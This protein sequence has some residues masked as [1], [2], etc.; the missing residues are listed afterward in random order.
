MVPFNRPHLTG[1]E[2]EFFAQAL[3]TGLMTGDRPFTSR[4]GALLSGMLGGGQTLLT[5]SCTHALELSAM[6]LDLGP[7]DEVI[8]PSFTFSSVA[9]AIV[10]RG[11]VP[12]F[13]DI[14]PDTFNL[15]ERLVESAITDRTR[16]V[17]TVHYGGVACAIEELVALCE[18]NDLALVEDNAHG[19]G[20]TYKD[21]PL[22]SFGRLATQSF[23][24]TKNVQCGDGGALVINDPDLVE[25]AEILRDKGTD[26]NR[27]DRGQ[28][29]KYVWRDIG[30]SYLLSDLLAAILFTQLE[31]FESIQTARHHIWR[32]Y[33][34]ELASWRAAN[35]VE[36]Q[37]IPQDTQHPAH[38]YA[39]MMPNALDRD[40]LIKHLAQSG[41]VANFHYVPLDTSPGGQRFGR[42]APGGCPVT[43]EVSDRLVRLPLFSQM[44]SE[45]LG[46]VIEATS[47]YTCR[48]LA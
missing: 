46:L 9:N 11:A 22:G 1:R 14:R 20:G 8:L 23:H 6:L 44:T 33:A 7:G 38:L 29:D 25:R 30:S 35:D 10:L 17:V 47:D 36:V 19:L 31:N 24:V 2:E 12:V 40:L 41:I 26:R 21:Q 32:S 15:D 42:T 45:Q 16:A 5:P 48:G 37:H 13:V 28:V 18:S 43:A 27:F 34:E 3:A 39:L 4:V